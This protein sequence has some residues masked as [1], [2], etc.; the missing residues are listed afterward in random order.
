MWENAHVENF[1]VTVQGQI[2]P[3][4]EE[5]KNSAPRVMHADML[6]VLEKLEGVTLV[7]QQQ[8]VELRTCS[9]CHET[10]SEWLSPADPNG[11]HQIVCINCLTDMHK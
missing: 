6:A 11:E 10:V 2:A 7:S 9:E 3:M 8:A 4:P 1:I 5:V